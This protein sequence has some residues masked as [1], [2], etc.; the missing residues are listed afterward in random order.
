MKNS[1]AFI[2]S[3]VI[4]L[5]CIGFAMAA[6]DHNSSRSNK[7]SSI[8]APD[9][10][11]SDT[12]SGSARKVFVLPHVLEKSGTTNAAAKPCDPNTMDCG[13]AAGIAVNEE[14]TAADDKGLK[15]KEKGNRTKTMSTG[16]QEPSGAS[17]ESMMENKDSTKSKIKMSHGDEAGTLKGTVK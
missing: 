17:N 3:F 2:L 4:A 16:S 9:T 1:N 15:V 6:Q 7:T 5:I 10:V 11:N 12:G 14:G 8:A 13:G